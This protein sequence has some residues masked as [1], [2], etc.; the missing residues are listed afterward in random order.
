MVEGEAYVHSLMSGEV[1]DREDIEWD[2]IQIE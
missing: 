2:G 1:F